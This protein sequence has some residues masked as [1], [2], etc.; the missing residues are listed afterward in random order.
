VSI[1]WYLAEKDL[2]ALLRD[3]MALF[4]VLG[5]PLVFGVFLAA[6]L[7]AGLG[8]TTARLGVQ[9][10]DES[11][12]SGAQAL[13]DAVASSERLSSVHSDRRSALDRVRR[14]EAAAALIIEPAAPGQQPPFQLGIV[15]DPARELDGERIR[16]E[17]QRALLGLASPELASPE[18][19]LRE[20]ALPNLSAMPS[21][22][23]LL[24]AAASPSAALRPP[25]VTL[26]RLATGDLA[27][28]PSDYV[29]APAVLWGLIGCAA[30]FAISLVA[31]RSRGTL[32]RLAA[33][34][35][36][37][38]QILLGKALACAL[39]CLAVAALIALVMG[40]GFSVR[41]PSPPK[42]A[43]ALLSTA[44]CFSGITMLLSV[45]GKTEQSV[46]GAGWGALIVLAMLG[47]GM[48]P[49]SLMPAWLADLGQVSPVRWGIVAL[50]GAL[51][52][53]FS[54]AE[55]ARSCAVLIAI[56]VVS[57]GVGS[58]FLGRAFRY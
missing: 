54:Y 10:V 23:A 57:F 24:S 25:T 56:G 36:H 4:W 8:G 49:L 51:W 19:T 32:R 7:E 12:A 27:R 3:R 50:E 58:A 21:A 38:R 13:L 31:E 43:L 53:G 34:P 16:A 18:L 45:L 46:A 15:I 6:V 20:L 30:C 47:G 40:V 29:F 11:G 2:R 39:A 28:R 52:R 37:K 48:V 17:V 14:G 44:L 26:E 35:I 1:V 55:L 22:R 42:L 33:A 9:V 41:F 5:F